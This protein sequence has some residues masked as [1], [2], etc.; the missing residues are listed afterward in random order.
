M[1]TATK[2]F[3]SVL[4]TTEAAATEISEREQPEVS[5]NSDEMENQSISGNMRRTLVIKYLSNNQATVKSADL[6]TANRTGVCTFCS[7]VLITGIGF[8]SYFLAIH[9]MY[10]RLPKVHIV[11][12]VLGVHAIVCKHVGPIG[13]YIAFALGCTITMPKNTTGNGSAPGG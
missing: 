7:F 12:C 5:M 6:E 11:P 10:R 3:T 8:A 2:T 13:Y 4:S 9:K 1:L